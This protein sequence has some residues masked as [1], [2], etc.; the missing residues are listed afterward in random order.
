MPIYE[1]TCHKC[2]KKFEALIM[3]GDTPKCPVCGASSV[4]RL[5]SA[6][7]FVSKGAGGETASRSASASSCAGCSSSSCSSC[8]S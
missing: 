3:G 6:C 2:H 4:K 7:G 8:G 1:Y 5:M